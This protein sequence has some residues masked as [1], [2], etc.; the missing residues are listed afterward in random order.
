MRNQFLGVVLLWCAL[1]CAG[2][3]CSP[4]A[5][6][7]PCSRKPFCRSRSTESTV[8]YF[9][10]QSGRAAL[11]NA[12]SNYDASVLHKT[13]PRCAR[14][15]ECEIVPRGLRTLRLWAPTP[16]FLDTCSSRTFFAQITP[17]CTRIFFIVSQEG[18]DS[19]R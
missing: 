19:L 1:C 16:T 10:L 3:L 17:I 5:P 2:S 18:S 4:A 12:K 7:Q 13:V 6:R 14:N 9:E 15:Y 11:S 8:L